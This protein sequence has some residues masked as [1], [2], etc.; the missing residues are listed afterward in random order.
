MRTLG[1][2]GG[3]NKGA[4]P[5]WTPLKTLN[6]EGAVQAGPSGRE[7]KGTGLRLE[8]VTQGC[9]CQSQPLPWWEG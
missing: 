5:W 8:S 4:S 7:Q 9:N 1:S 2:P 6:N 3:N